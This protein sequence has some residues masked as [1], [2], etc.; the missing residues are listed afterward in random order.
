MACELGKSH[1]CC[2]RIEHLGV[3]VGS[4]TILHDV[5]LHLHCGE[6]TAII[7]KNGAGK[8]T[9]IK[10]L[11]NMIP[12]SGTITFESERSLH[13][14]HAGA[15]A[16]QVPA[17]FVRYRTKPV[18]TT[19]PRFGYVPQ[20]IFFEKESPVSVE[21]VVLAAVS[22]WPVWFPHRKK[23][24]ELVR[25]ILKAT[26]VHQLSHRRMGELS[27]GEM[28]RVLL[29]LA[30]FPLPD[31]LLLDEPVSGVD[32]GGLSVFYDLVSS[33]RRNYDM[34][35]LLVSHDLDLVAKHA[36]RVVFFDQGCARVGTVH[37][38]Y[39]TEEFSQAF[40]ALWPPRAVQST[41]ETTV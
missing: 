7:G 15:G 25:E 24:R 19:K 8:T 6:L 20:S 41:E 31:I 9:F 4:Q 5:N 14:E 37:D 23:D 2:T 39:Q 34:T 33:L 40:G 16:V 36:D 21:D 18:T 17:G 13:R 11:L 10:A 30:I 1:V 3:K 26:N 32:R 38:T 35:I 28:Q 12:H 22:R 29:A 27:G